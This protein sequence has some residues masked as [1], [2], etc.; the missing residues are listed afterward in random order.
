M[1]ADLCSKKK[2]DRYKMWISKRWERDNRYYEAH[3]KRDLSDWIAAR[4]LGGIG[5]L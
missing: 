2:Y 1:N 3:L 4:N 5:S